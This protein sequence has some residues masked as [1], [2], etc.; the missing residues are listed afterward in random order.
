MSETS[1]DNDD[2]IAERDKIRY[3]FQKTNLKLGNDFD[4][5]YYSS[6]C[7]LSYKAQKKV[8][9]DLSVINPYKSNT[10]LKWTSSGNLEDDKILYKSL[11]LA[12]QPFPIVT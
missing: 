7:K 3:K 1:M 10:T 6:V 2:T 4:S 8:E 5:K 12:Q 11:S 9:N